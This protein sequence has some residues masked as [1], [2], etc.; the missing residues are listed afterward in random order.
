MTSGESILS[1]K[2]ESD[3]RRHHE[4]LLTEQR[5]SMLRLYH[6]VSAYEDA[7]TTVTCQILVIISTSLQRHEDSSRHDALLS[8]CP[9]ATC[10]YFLHLAQLEAKMHSSLVG[11]SECV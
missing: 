6:A 11:G 7:W 4:P 10:S 2:T 5:R 1:S 8:A 3:E 9:S